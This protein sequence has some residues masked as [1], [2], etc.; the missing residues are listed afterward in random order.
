MIDKFKKFLSYLKREDKNKVFIAMWMDDKYPPLLAAIKASL[1]LTGYE[2][3][4]IDDISHNNQIT[5]EIFSRIKKSPFIVADFT[6]GKKEG[7]RGNVFYEA[8]YARGAGIEVVH[9][10]KKSILKK[11]QLSF[12]TSQFTHIP[13]KNLTPEAMKVFVSKLSEH[14]EGSIGSKIK[15]PKFQLEKTKGTIVLAGEDNSREAFLVYTDSKGKIIAK[16]ISAS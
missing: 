6:H 3:Y 13:W 7:A 2:G 16:K 14:I 4:R 11:Q 8:G 5:E 15:K 1:E 9:T 10:C 12:D